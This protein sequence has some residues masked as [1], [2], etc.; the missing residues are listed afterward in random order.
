MPRHFWTTTCALFAGLSLLG[1]GPAADQSPSPAP[2][3]TVAST[4]P[5]STPT[6]LLK[7]DVSTY[8]GSGVQSSTDGPLLSATFTDVHFIAA[9]PDR[10]SLF[11]TDKNEIRELTKGGAVVTIAGAVASGVSDGKGADARFNEPRRHRV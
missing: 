5:T 1:A 9:D 2:A 8:A 11:V 4:A 10:Q 3:S 7:R 6:P